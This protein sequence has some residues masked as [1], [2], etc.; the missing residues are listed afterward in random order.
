MLAFLCEK[1]PGIKKHVIFA[2]TGWEH[3]GIIDWCRGIVSKFGLELIVVK[4]AKKTF[5][6][7]AEE[8][9][10]FPGMSQRQC[11]SDLKRDPI[12]KWIRNNVKDPVIISC[13]GLRSEESDNRKKG[14]K[15]KRNKRESNGKRTIW[16]WSPIKEWKESEVLSYLEL[17]EIPLHPVYKYL[18]R[19]SCRMCIYMKKHDVSQV[20]KHDPG[21]IEIISNIEKKI[22]FSFFKDGFLNP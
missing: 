9:G 13:M 10:K 22:N 21:A 11:T 7:M 6:S 1:Y 19:L 5:L 15:L 12:V 16:D 14:K 3:E 2:N 20:R 17:K 18:R 8:R 4:N